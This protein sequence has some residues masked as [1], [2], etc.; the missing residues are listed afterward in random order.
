M[1]PVITMPER[2]GVNSLWGMTRSEGNITE[3]QNNN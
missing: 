1:I 3:E 2:S